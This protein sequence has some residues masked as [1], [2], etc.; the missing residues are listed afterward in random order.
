VYVSYI[1]EQINTG[2]YLSQD[3]ALMEETNFDFDQ[4]AGET[5]SNLGDITIWQSVAGIVIC[6]TVLLD[7]TMS[8]GKNPPSIIFKG[9]Y[10]RGTRVWKECTSNEVRNSTLHSQIHGWMDEKWFLDL[11]ERGWK[12]FA[13]RPA[14]SGHGSYIIMDEVNFHLIPS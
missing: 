10:T 6:C 9:K 3:I 14:T 5:F 7:V 2:H 11:T 4:E 13:A 1:N 12:P 8:G